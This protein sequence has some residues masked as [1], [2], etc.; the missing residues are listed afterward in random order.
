[1]AHIN[2]CIVDLLAKTN[3]MPATEHAAVWV[4]DGDAST[5]MHCL[6]TKFTPINRRHHCRKCGAVVCG[7]CSN[8]KFLLSYQAERPLRVCISC[9]DALT[10]QQAEADRSSP[11]PSTFVTPSQ[12]SQY[13][14][15]S[16]P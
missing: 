6:K 8:R 15:C 12:R 5:C 10:A 14:V 11:P 3:K 1:M 9:Y 4:P 2:K 7:A 13:E 16:R